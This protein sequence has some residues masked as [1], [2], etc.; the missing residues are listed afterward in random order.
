[1]VQLFARL[2]LFAL[3]IFL[4]TYGYA[5]NVLP[6][7]KQFISTNEQAIISEYIQF[8]SIPNV[9][10]DTAN[11]PGNTAFIRKMMEQHGIK[12]ELLSAVTPGVNPAV[13]GE[14][15]V[16]GA[17]TT[18]AFY[19]H[20][21]G[22]PVNA[23]QWAPGL[24]PFKPVFIT[25]PIESGGTIVNYT[26]GTVVDHNWRL[27]GRGS[28][29]DKAGVMTIINGYA[30]LQKSGM[31]LKHNIK[32]FFEGEEE[33]G[34][35]HLNEIFIKYKEK[36][37][38]DIWIVSDGPRHVSGKKLVQF[39]VRGD[40]NMNLTVYG[41]KRP[42]H[43]GNY[44]NWA[45]NP[46]MMLVQLLAGMKDEKG[47]I[48]IK[49]FYND[50]IPLTETE[51]KAIAAIPDIEETLKA[52]LG[53]ALP[54]GDGKSFLALLHL[55]TLNIN[56][57]NS[58]NTGKLAANIIPVKAEATLDLRLVAGNDVERQVQKVIQHII[59]KGY[60]L[61]DQEPTDLERKKYGKLI[62]I[63]RGSGYNAQR[64]PMDLPIAQYVIKAVQSTVDYPVV[65]LPSAGGSLPLYLFEKILNAKVITVPVVNYDNNQH[66]ENENMKIGYLL[67]GIET[68]A[69]IMLMN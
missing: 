67:E 13:F 62:K 16:P 51:K 2:L 26:P 49:D 45:P 11:I 6:K 1:M 8:V 46:A 18:I 34:S 44:G 54:D 59:S 63:T 55:P 56:G 20:Y 7:I 3:L 52:E 47:N 25:A 31:P 19:A 14:V 10:S 12:T 5:Q 43:S 64:T 61:I 35:I 28:A 57:I 9:S 69:A 29:D 39:G 41:A 48:L 23:K 68:M 37:K 27:T 50:V 58:A 33:V 24:E 53:I 30:A 15:K 22:Q 60:Q 21:D 32:F 4:Q 36:L 40:V 42:L 38:A 65:L 66:A 17:T